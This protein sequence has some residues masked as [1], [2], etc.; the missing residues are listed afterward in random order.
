MNWLPPS[1]LG[2][3]SGFIVDPRFWRSLSR[4]F[5]SSIEVSSGALVM[6]YKSG[7]R[8]IIPQIKIHRALPCLIIEIVGKCF[9][10]LCFRKRN[11]LFLFHMVFF[12]QF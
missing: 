2:E 3:N 12:G 10:T 11:F 4:N 8:N 1:L 9:E 7:L 5:I 6:L